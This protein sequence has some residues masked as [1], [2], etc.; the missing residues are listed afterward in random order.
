MIVPSVIVNDSEPSDSLSSVAA[1]G[2][3]CVAPAALFA[4]KVTV[5][6]VAPRSEP[7][8]AS[9]PSGALHATVT[10]APTALDSVTVKTASLPSDTLADGP[11]MLSSAESRSSGT[12]VVPLSSSVSVT[13]A[14]LTLRP[15][16][17]VAP[18][19]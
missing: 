2:M 15:A 1:M 19:S 18:G 6:D 11:D 13:V 4:A 12:L 16:T 14:E 10:S 3:L 17:V 7:S 8:A 9:V 5:S